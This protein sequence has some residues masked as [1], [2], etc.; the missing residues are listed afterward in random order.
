MIHPKI[1]AKQSLGRNRKLN[2][3]FLQPKHLSHLEGPDYTVG[4]SEVLDP[5]ETEKK[6]MFD[7]E[8]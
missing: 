8:V 3:G 4:L 6:A 5:N 7:T 2:G 1:V